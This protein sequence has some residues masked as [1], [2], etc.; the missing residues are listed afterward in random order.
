MKVIPRTNSRPGKDGKMFPIAWINGSICFFSQEVPV[1]EEIEVMITGRSK[2]QIKLPDGSLQPAT[3]FVAPVGKTHSLIAVRGFESDYIRQKDPKPDE[4]SHKEYASAFM[5]DD[6]KQKVKSGRIPVYRV[7]VNMGAKA[8]A[9]KL[10]G[11]ELWVE[12]VPGR[13]GLYNA[14]GLE[15]PKDIDHMVMIQRGEMEASVRDNNDERAKRS[16][17]TERT[18]R[19][20]EPRAERPAS[21][22]SHD[23]HQGR[24][25]RAMEYAFKAAAS[26]RNFQ[27][28]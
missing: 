20:S 13:T 17:T 2:T 11:C 7:H 5:S 27:N 12:A 25:A 8:E 21:R 6:R 23:D 22:A 1:E 26:R 19:S 4:P 15:N 14:V 18:E 16:K 3:L 9:D 28:A 10:H 24:S